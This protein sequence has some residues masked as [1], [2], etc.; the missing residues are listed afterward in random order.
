VDA[1]GRAIITDFGL[2]KVVH[3]AV[4]FDN[5]AREDDQQYEQTETSPSPQYSVTARWLAP[6]LICDKDF[7]GPSPPISTASDVWSFGC[8]CLEVRRIFLFSLLFFS[9]DK[10]IV[11]D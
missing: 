8:L 9:F 5:G 7:D 6:E 4:L 1:N 3:E 11:T 10:I 2:S